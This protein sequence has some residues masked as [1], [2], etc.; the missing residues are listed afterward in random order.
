MTLNHYETTL[1]IHP[2]LSKRD[3]DATI[4][5]YRKLLKAEKATIVHEDHEGLQHLA[6]PIKKQVN[7][8]YHVTQYHA[9]GS[10][11]DKLEKNYRIDEN[12]IR[13]L[14]IKLD[15]YGISYHQKKREAHQAQP[16]AEQ[17]QEGAT[18][19]G[20]IDTKPTNEKREKKYCRFTK[21]EIKYI[22]YKEKNFLISFLNPQGKILPRRI[23]GNSAKAQRMVN[24]AIKRARHTARIPFVTD[25][26]K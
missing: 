6:Y 25:N 1:I 4:A 17:G 26:L 22:D 7:G 8:I 11:V 9:T 19:E 16:A 21:F 18:Q 3:A 5:K 2:S 24:Q 12:V 13:F 10:V 15:K 20:S 23:T 14:S